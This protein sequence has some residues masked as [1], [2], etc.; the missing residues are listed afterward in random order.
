MIRG[1]FLL[2]DKPA[3]P[4]SNDVLQQVKRTMTRCVGSRL[5][6]GHAGTL[7][8]FASGLLVVLVGNMTRLTPWFMHQSKEYEAV[9][10]FGKE[11][12]TLDPNGRVIAECEPPSGE[13]LVSVLPRFEG[14]IMQV[15][16]AYSAVHS[17]GERAYRQAMRGQQPEL[18]ARPVMIER[19]AL[20]SWDG[21]RATLS[22]RCSAGTYVRALA[23]DAGLACGS[24][25]YV[26]A[27]RRIRIGPFVVEDAVSP[28]LCSLQ[29]LRA[30][31]PELAE[32]LG[33]RS[34]ILRH[35]YLSRF[36]HGARLS[37]AAIEISARGLSFEHLDA[38]PVSA[39]SEGSE[40]LA[41]FA[42]V[43]NWPGGNSQK[44]EFLGIIQERGDYYQVRLVA[45]ERKE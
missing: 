43:E 11:T 25:A 7:D 21:L 19:C 31:T 22:I 38:Y 5:K 30:F 18:Q 24:R 15:P 40:E 8:S 45:A 16:P 35:E 37:K 27:L 9:F 41:L 36:L 2:I 26:E 33:L 39:D 28:E 12:D 29:T 1:G 20:R 23:R 17:G 14:S 34:A 44:L 32:G 6:Y 4:T 13:E 10:R 3:G 42:P